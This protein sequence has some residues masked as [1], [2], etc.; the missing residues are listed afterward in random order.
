MMIRKRTTLTTSQKRQ[1]LFLFLFGVILL[2]AG[3]R[4]LCVIFL[5]WN[6]TTIGWTR[7]IGDFFATKPTLSALFMEGVS[8]AGMFMLGLF[9]LGFSAIGQPAV[10]VLLAV[11]GF[12]VGSVLSNTGTDGDHL[13]QLICLLPYHVPASLLLVVAARESMRFSGRLS[14]FVFQDDPAEQ[15]LHQLRLYCI[16]FAVLAILI[17]LLAMVYGLAFYAFQ[18]AGAVHETGILKKG[19]D[20][21]WVCLAVT[22]NVPVPA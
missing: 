22:M 3:A 15:M 17:L 11:Y 2:G 8:G 12:C 13:L 10:M 14:T 18:T 21:L 20:K 6:D 1:R 19:F 9:M 7:C 5:E 16:R 4:T